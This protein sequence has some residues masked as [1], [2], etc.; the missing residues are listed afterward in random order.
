MPEEHTI[1]GNLLSSSL[2][3]SIHTEPAGPHIGIFISFVRARQ[4]DEAANINSY[5]VQKLMK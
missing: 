4:L 5:H 1:L 3:A 2:N